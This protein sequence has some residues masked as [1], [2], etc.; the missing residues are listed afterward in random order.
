MIKTNELF[1]QLDSARENG[2]LIIQLTQL[3]LINNEQNQK[4]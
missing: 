3:K 2:L 4:N 1:L